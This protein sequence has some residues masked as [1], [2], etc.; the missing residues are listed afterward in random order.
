MARKDKHSGRLED[1]IA[2]A[3]TEKHLHS[4]GAK[5]FD[6]GNTDEAIELFRKAI[7]IREHSYTRY[8]CGLAYLRNNQVH[9]A[10]IELSKAI[11]LDPDVPEYY[12]ERSHMFRM[13]GENVN[14]QRDEERANGLDSNYARIEKIKASLQAVKDALSGPAWLDGIEKKKIRSSKLREIVEDLSKARTETQGMFERA[15]CSLP[16][17]S[18]CCHFSSETILHGVYIGPWKL[19]AIREFLR[20]KDLCEDRYLGKMLYDGE[21]YLKE[22]IPLQYIVGEKGQQWIF[23]P[24]RQEKPPPK[25]FLKDLP[26]GNDYQTLI[27]IDEKARACVFLE[28]GRCVIHDTGDEAG[29]PSC[30]EFLC[31][32]GFVFVVL[33]SLGLLDDMKISHQKMEDLN[34]IAIDSLLILASELY[35]HD[36]VIQLGKLME[37]LLKKAIEADGLGKEHVVKRLAGEYKRANATHE[38]LFSDQKKRLRNP[39]AQLFKDDRPG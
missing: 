29:L 1:I 25:V 4:K 11:E 2:V 3:F 31:L 27:W 32:T 17:P 16:C 21:N 12:A 38:R 18:Y 9:E 15:S 20:E 33:K 14:A 13:I 39:I 10:I 26:R 35:G 24:L 36:R 19:H 37:D 5:S 22:L 7:G 6:E 8:H 23:Y 30:K 28:E 34:R